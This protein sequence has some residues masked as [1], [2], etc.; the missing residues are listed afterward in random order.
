MI[1]FKWTPPIQ[2]PENAT[3]V[4]REALVPMLFWTSV[5]VVR[6]VYE[7][8]TV[9]DRL[10][11]ESAIMLAPMR[12]EDVAEVTGIPAEVV[13][14]IAE[15]LT[16]LG[17]LDVDGGGY[18]AV[19]EVAGAALARLTVPEYRTVTMTFLFLPHTGD[20]VAYSPGSRGTTPPPLH[21]GAPAEH[22]P[23]PGGVSD[24]TDLLRSRIRARDVIGLP[25]D[26]VDAVEPAEPMR[27]EA[28][29]P[30]Y[31]C[32][33]WISGA[34][35]ARKLVLKVRESGGKAPVSLPLDGATRQAAE[36]TALADQAAHAG[37]AWVDSGGTVTVEREGPLDWVYR[38]DAA[39][40]E[41]A[42]SELP[43]TPTVGLEIRTETCVLGVNVR[44]I[45]AEPAARRVFA[46]HD[47]VRRLRNPG[48]GS[49][50]PDALRG[51]IE[52]ARAA[53]ELAADDVTEDDVVDLLWTSGHWPQVYALRRDRDFCYD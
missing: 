29:C 21:R 8:L 27:I 14:R 53:Y 39:A 12:P 6:L 15:R 13:T 1:T 5:P 23:M 40:A 33:G 48:P 9:V 37:S 38:L 25:D 19:A 32:S 42:G 24:F 43:L 34:G 35:V 49:L 47:A 4:V 11:V 45:A 2:V 16:G 31:R 7:E 20:L 52:Q 10:V 50:D 26:I 46:R 18:R 44:L 3:V 17:L 30:A 36:W 51:A 41:A 28:D 22:A